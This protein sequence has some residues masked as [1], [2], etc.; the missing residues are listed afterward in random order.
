M[1]TDYKYHSG[2]STEDGFILR[3]V[4]GKTERIATMAVS[5]RDLATLLANGL[6]HLV[7]KA[8]S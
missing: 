4:V 7:K 8:R 5:D 2:D 6:D 3:V 1:A